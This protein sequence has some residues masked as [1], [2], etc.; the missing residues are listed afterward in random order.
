MRLVPKLEIASFEGAGREWDL[1]Q[2]FVR[3][4]GLMVLKLLLVITL[5]VKVKVTL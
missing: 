1:K 5:I 4:N 2:I 3:N